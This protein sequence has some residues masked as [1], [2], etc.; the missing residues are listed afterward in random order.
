MYDS[1]INETELKQTRVNYLHLHLFPKI[2]GNLKF[3]DMIG[4]KQRKLRE[5]EIFVT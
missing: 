4:L 2:H 1:K 3:S 5:T